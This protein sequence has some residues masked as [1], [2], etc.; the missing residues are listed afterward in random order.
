M[1]EYLLN[2]KRIERC[3]LV[4]TYVNLMLA[5]IRTKQ[6]KSYQGIT[7][8][9][10]TPR[11]LVTVSN[12]IN[13]ERICRMMIR[14]LRRIS[15]SNISVALLSIYSPSVLVFFGDDL[16]KLKSLV[17]ENGMRTTIIPSCVDITNT[18]DISTKYRF[19]AETK[20][21]TSHGVFRV[22]AYHND[23]TKDEAIALIVGNGVTD[24]PVRVHDQCAT[25]ETF[26][27]LRCDCKEQ[28]DSALAHIQTV[29]EGMV[30][31]LHQEG[32]G[33]G[34]TNK[35]A[36]YSIQELGIDTVDANRILG[37]PDDCRRYEV[38]KDILEDLHIESICIMTNNPRKIEALNNLGIKIV[39]RHSCIVKPNSTYSSHY[40]QTK[41][42]RMGHLIPVHCSDRSYDDRDQL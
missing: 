8:L 7:S 9:T 23:V 34:L 42:T 33:I 19:I 37:L 5:F 4:F 35:I 29:G 30:I 13:I 28:L 15:I 16:S 40:V 27:S 3:P 25:S 10:D 12:D 38:V 1:E 24:V 11:L 22:R 32:R 20:L 14:L 36:A 17:I 21:P 2:C 26:G 41:A 18:T 6:W 31:Y 39:D